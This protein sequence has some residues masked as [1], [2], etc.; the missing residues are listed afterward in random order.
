MLGLFDSGV[1]GLTVVK[2]LLKRSPNAS[3]VYLGDTARAPYGNKSAE[4]IKRYAIED[5][6]FL[7][8]HGATSIAVACNTAS[9][10]ALDALRTT[11]PS[12]RFFDVISPSIDATWRLRPKKVGVIG[13]RATIGSSVYERS[14][15]TISDGAIDIISAA[16]P[17]FVPFVEENWIRKP[18]TKRIAK[19]YLAKIRQKQVDALILGCTHYPLL[20]NVIRSSLQK[21]VRIVNAAAAILDRIAAEAPELMQD[22]T[23]P[24]QTFYFTDATAQTQAIADR[25]LGKHV[26]CQTTEL[27]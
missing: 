13:T 19:T 12:V 25:W 11:Y 27:L 1:G 14:L 6:R 15:K 18:E 16:C 20:Q 26:P 2:E 24:S 21:R 4:T 5:A 9:A 3:F 10:L 7:I 23:S 8:D 17:L 22:A